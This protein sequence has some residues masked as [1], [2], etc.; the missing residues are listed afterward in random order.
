[1][2]ST[3]REL[4]SWLSRAEAVQVGRMLVFALPGSVR[5]LE[6]DMEMLTPL[7]AHA[8][9]MMDGVPHA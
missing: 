3:C 5:A 8:V 9:A 6:Q 7:L 4:G 1:M 2:S